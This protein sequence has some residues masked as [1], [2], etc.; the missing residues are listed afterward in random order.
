[1]PYDAFDLARV[2]ADFG[3][4]IQTTLDL[5]GYIPPAP[6]LTATADALLAQHGLAAT[7]NTAKVRSELL[8]APLLLEAW[9]AS[10]GR[11]TFYSGVALDVDAATELT[12]V[13][14]FIFGHLPQLDS[15]TRPV[16][17]VIEASETIMGGLGPCAAE[18]IAAQRFNHSRQP[19]VPTVYG[20]VTNGQGW[21][22]L[23]LTDAT[24]DIDMTQYL[25]ANPDRILRR[26]PELRRA[27]PGAGCGVSVS[28]AQAPERFLRGV[29]AG[30]E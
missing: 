8:V 21:R 26:H 6:V 11:V 27:G 22:F 19:E 4:T 12:G 18:M 30:A 14:D 24:L 2:Q 28:A 17:M 9:R 5:F 25:I 10:A 20:C 1:M 16:T 13:C 15:V 29:A 3:I 23:R 7:I